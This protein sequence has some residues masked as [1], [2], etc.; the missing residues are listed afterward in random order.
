MDKKD[1]VAQEHARRT[2]KRYKDRISVLN[3]DRSVLQETL[4]HERAIAAQRTEE[5]QS[6]IQDLRRDLHEVR[7]RQEQDEMNAA[8]LE[9]EMTLWKTKCLAYKKKVGVSTTSN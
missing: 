3:A 1:Q 5:L 2:K 7:S 6:K 4:D 9:N 8:S